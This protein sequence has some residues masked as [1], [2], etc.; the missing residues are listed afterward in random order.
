MSGDQFLRRQHQVALEKAACHLRTVRTSAE[1]ASH[2]LRKYASLMAQNDQSILFTA[3]EMAKLI[4]GSLNLNFIEEGN[5]FKTPMEASV[6][7]A[8]GAKAVESTLGVKL[9]LRSLQLAFIL[10]IAQYAD[11]VMAK[12]NF[13]PNQLEKYS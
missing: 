2:S 7:V 1:T 13:K 11:M 8:E 4:Q 9:N 6:L 5:P 10:A 12:G 3:N